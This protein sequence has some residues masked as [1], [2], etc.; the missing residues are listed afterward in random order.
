MIEACKAVDKD[1]KRVYYRWNTDFNIPHQSAD[2]LFYHR[3]GFCR[4]ACDVTLYAMRACGI[5]VA[6]EYFV[7][8]PEYQHPHFWT[9]LRDTT[10]KFIQFGFNEFEASRINPGTDGRKKGKVYRYCFGAQDELFSGITKDNKVPALFRDRFIKDVTANYFGE[11][12]VSVSVQ[13]APSFSSIIAAAI[14]PNR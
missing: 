13:S 4:E 12:E 5:P 3:V 11:N 14:S 8:S 6:S 10:G 7:Y 2:F 9:V 1:L